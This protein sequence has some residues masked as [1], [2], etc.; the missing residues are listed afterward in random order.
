[1]ERMLFVHS[2]K[3]FNFSLSLTINVSTMAFCSFVFLFIF[4][5]GWIIAHD[6]C[7]F[8]FLLSFYVLLVKLLLVVISVT[9]TEYRE[10]PG[11]YWKIFFRQ[12]S[13]LSSVCNSINDKFE[14]YFSFNIRVTQSCYF[15]IRNWIDDIHWTH[16]HHR[17]PY[18]ASKI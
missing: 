16:F 14:K 1:M 17:L 11:N 7:V 2:A 18:S 5:L 10:H 15:P 8:F 9:L 6:I 13:E 12:K 4:S 3:P